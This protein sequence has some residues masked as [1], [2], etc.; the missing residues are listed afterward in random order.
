MISL[1]KEY[2][3]FFG[4]SRSMGT[5][6]KKTMSDEVLDKTMHL[7]WEKG[8][9]NTSVDELIEVTGFNRRAIYKYFGGKRDLF[10]A[11]L[12]RYRRDMTPGFTA[13]LN[14]ASHGLQAIEEFFNQFIHL[15]KSTMPRGCFLIATASESPSHDEEIN[16][17]VRRFSNELSELF[18]HCLTSAINNSQLA[19]STNIK[20]VADFLVVNVFGLMTLHR[21]R[22]SNKTIEHHISIVTQ[23]LK[24]LR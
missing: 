23:F 2:V 6:I 11:M 16:E 7:F 17:F 18:Q 12:K 10:L 8:Y 9:F 4:K 20:S 21:T 13:P 1:K 19:T 14:H 24:T 3:F 5:V 22:S 15:D